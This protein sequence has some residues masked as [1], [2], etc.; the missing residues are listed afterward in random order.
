LPPL[1]SSRLLPLM[2]PAVRRW[3]EVRF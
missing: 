1:R 2:T 3:F